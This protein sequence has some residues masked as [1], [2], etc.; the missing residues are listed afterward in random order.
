[1]AKP[2]PIT[3]HIP[4][5]AANL[6][7]GYGVLAIALDLPLH[8]TIEPRTDG[9]L[10]VERADDPAAQH[11]PRHDPVLRGLRA[12]GELLGQAFGKGVTVHVDGTIPR[13]VGLGTISAGFAAGLGAAI[14]LARKRWTAGTLLDQLI[15]LGGDPAHGAAALLGGLTATVPLSPPREQP[16]RHQILQ[17]ILHPGWQFVVVMP[18]AQMGTAETKR[19]LP[20]TLPHAVAARTAGR[21]LGVLQ[22]LQH[23]DEAL[24]R[25]SLFDETHVPY[26]RHLVDGIEQALRAGL[27]AGAAGTTICGHGPGL[28]AL[29]MDPLRSQPIGKAMIG[30]FESA[31]R[32]ATALPLGIAHYGALPAQQ[33]H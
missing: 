25:D 33:G 12:G 16:T 30:A 19:V 15:A 20:P 31:G 7:P 14:R 24:L 6:G 18:D 23:G 27:D 21:V 8:I 28:L 5:S 32:R 29:T 17:Q 22:A 2:D 3:F 10:V 4:A 11:D 1:M 26:R 13:G 9:Q